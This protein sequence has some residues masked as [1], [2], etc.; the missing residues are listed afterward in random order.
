MHAGQERWNT[1]TTSEIIGSHTHLKSFASYCLHST[2]SPTLRCSDAGVILSLSIRLWVLLVEMTLDS[3]LPGFSSC[4]YHWPALC[5][6]QAS[7][8]FETPFP[9]FE[10]SISKFHGGH[11][12]M[13]KMIMSVKLLAEYLYPLGIKFV[14][15]PQFSFVHRTLVFRYQRQKWRWLPLSS[16]LFA[17]L[18]PSPM[19]RLPCISI[20]TWYGRMRLGQTSLDIKDQSEFPGLTL[21]VNCI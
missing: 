7:H 5:L 12:K 3:H 21:F 19:L 11:L 2:S 13:N 15:S 18:A 1:G 6:E 14:L 16:R 9:P 20:P 10:K 17:E 8:Y 4:L